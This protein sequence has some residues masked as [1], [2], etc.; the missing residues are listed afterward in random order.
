MMTGTWWLWPMGKAACIWMMIASVA[1]RWLG[2]ELIL[3]DTHIHILDPW[4]WCC[5]LIES[6]TRKGKS[7]S[8]I[9]S[10]WD[11]AVFL[12]MTRVI[13]SNQRQ[14]RLLVMKGREGMHTGKASVAKAVLFILTDDDRLCNWPFAKPFW[15]GKK[16][17]SPSN[18]TE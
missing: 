5:L 11:A 15:T 13:Y 4:D 1:W 2:T 6:M 3:F 10:E 18:L 16:L 9:M 7:S 12:R 17:I 14:S 8:F